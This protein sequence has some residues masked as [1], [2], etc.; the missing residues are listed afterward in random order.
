VRAIAEATR[1]RVPA[2]WTVPRVTVVVPTKNEGRT[3]REVIERVQ[4]YAD[5]I[6]V[7]DGHSTDDTRRIAL[8]HGARVELDGGRGKGDGVRTAI[9]KAKGDVLVFI[10]ADG[11]HEPS[12][13][14]KLLDPILGDRADLVIG[15]RGTGGSDESFGTIPFFLRNTGGHLI[16]LAINYRFGVRLTDSQNGFR[17]IRTEVARALDLEEDLT[18]IEQEMLIK[19]LKRRYR[20]T[21]VPSHEYPRR[22]GCSRI[23]LW[24]VWHVYVWSVLKNLL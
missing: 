9:E 3:I 23:V 19:A 1:E 11:S 15:S 22:F 7:V 6:L 14:P 8:E 24:R 21:E 13:I 18:T 20:V 16:L 2:D 12:D 5:E 4:P 17:A 10:D